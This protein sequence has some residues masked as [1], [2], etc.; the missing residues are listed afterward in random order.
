MWFIRKKQPCV[1]KKT[2]PRLFEESAKELEK[3]VDILHKTI[4]FKVTRID[5][6]EAKIEALMALHPEAMRHP[7]ICSY[8]NRV[9]SFYD[10]TKKEDK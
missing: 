7:S 6:I 1:E 4:D 5:A 10:C 8:N 3:D 9:E 2:T